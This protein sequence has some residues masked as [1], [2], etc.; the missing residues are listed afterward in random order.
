MSV[1]PK[2]L[3]KD[4]TVHEMIKIT[5]IIRLHAQLTRQTIDMTDI[6]RLFLTFDT[7]F[8]LFSQPFNDPY[9]YSLEREP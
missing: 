8:D 7:Q 2:D 5:P 1:V 4:I 6:S 3:S 9:R